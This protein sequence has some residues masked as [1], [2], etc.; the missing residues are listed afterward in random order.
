M[1]AGNVVSFAGNLQGI[2]V[3][4]GNYHRQSLVGSNWNEVRLGFLGTLIG[5][6]GSDGHTVVESVTVASYLDWLC[7]GLMNTRA[8]SSIIPG[9][10]AANFA[11][12]VFGGTNGHAVSVGDN[13]AGGTNIIC[14]SSDMKL[15]SM[16]GVSVL[17]ATAV[18]NSQLVVGQYSATVYA[19]S[20][21]L[22]FVVNNKG[23]SNQT[24]TV[25]ESTRWSSATAITQATATP[26]LRA[27]LLNLTYE[28]PTVLTWN[29]GGVAL[30]LPDCWFF[31]APFYSNALRIADYMVELIS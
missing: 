16:A 31:R 22:K 1:S 9:V 8:N 21:L 7:L 28:N 19:M 30:P 24:L 6:A 11:G 23:A 12:L 10:A 20:W 5:G 18:S 4:R 29:S 26:T 25:S 13:T 15:T 27:N 2:P 14:S 17:T 3:A